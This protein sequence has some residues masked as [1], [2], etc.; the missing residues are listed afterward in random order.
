MNRPVAPVFA[1]PLLLVLLLLLPL[2][3]SCS[4]KEEKAAPVA[5]PPVPVTLGVVALKRVPVELTAFGTV[6][7][8][9]T[10]AVKSRVSGELIKVH[11]REGDEV[12][13]G[14]LLFTID[15]RPFELAV[16]QAEAVLARDRIQ[17]A[18]ARLKAE[19]YR[20]LLE[21]KFV[22]PQEYEQLAT[23]AD[24]FTSLV[25]V[26]QAA[27]DNARLQLDYCRIRAPL[28]G[29]TGRVA[30]DPGTLVKG[31]DGDTLVTIHQ[32]APVDVVFSIP[33]RQLMR[34]QQAQGKAPVVVSAIPDK[35]S[36]EAES[37]VV[38]FIDNSVD[39]TTGT[40]RVKATFANNDRHLWPGS[41]VRVILQIGAAQEVLTVPSAAVQI[42]QKGSYVYGVAADGSASV[43]PV[44][45][46]IE[47]Q[48]M[49]VI[50]SGLSAGDSIV[51]DGQSRLYPGA[52]VSTTSPPEPKKS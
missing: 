40:V 43:R 3:T 1:R 20:Q 37:G 36:G 41:F 34:L 38:D 23:E 13:Q 4:R 49:T 35:S 39:A 9:S 21:G 28:A 48:G 42:G 52:K 10:V 33:D 51:V 29:R 17:A 47:W 25:G 32:L 8:R 26:D 45:A 46:G 6:E 22:S 15:S 27:L 14:D 31:T 30:V 7:A 11:I 16:K 19:R 2:L 44:K 24:A 50:E 18:N 12:R 5:K